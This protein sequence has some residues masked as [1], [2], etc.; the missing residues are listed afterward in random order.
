MSSFHLEIITAER[1]VYSDD[2]TSLTAPGTEGTLGILAHHAPLMTIIQPGQLVIKKD[3][4]EQ[5]LI[6]T[7]GFLEVRP[8]SVIV[9]ADAA[10]YSEEIDVSRAEEAKRRAE[11]RLKTA[12]TGEEVDRFRAEAALRRAVARLKVAEHRKRRTMPPA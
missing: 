11:E 10:E 6:V 2:V 5:Y 4:Q 12:G 7:G 8:D 1:Q 3:G 9:L